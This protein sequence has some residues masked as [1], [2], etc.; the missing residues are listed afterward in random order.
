MYIDV[1][2]LMSCLVNAQIGDALKELSGTDNSEFMF[3]AVEND[4]SGDMNSLFLD[5]NT[6]HST[7]LG[8]TPSFGGYSAMLNSS[9]DNVNNDNTPSLDSV[10][11]AHSRLGTF[12]L[13]GE[14]S[15]EEVSVGKGVGVANTKHSSTNLFKDDVNFGSQARRKYESTENSDESSVQ[16]NERK[17]MS[18]SDF[19]AIMELP[20]CTPMWDAVQRF[21]YS[22]L[23][24]GDGN[25]DTQ[26][27]LFTKVSKLETFQGTKDLDTRCQ[28][29]FDDFV[30]YCTK[31]AKFK[32]LQY[33][34]LHFV[35][36]CITLDLFRLSRR[37]AYVYA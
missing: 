32:G 16:W 10:K 33:L 23:G 27:N 11:A 19:L 26:K 24:D 37:P 6:V 18:Y 34:F 12:G 3:G 35:Y 15:D 9:R 31:H 8:T 1:F 21:V 4:L 14:G 28:N 20:D 36:A 5:G 2:E 13:F 17:S 25:L 22:V 7:V 29:F 30:D